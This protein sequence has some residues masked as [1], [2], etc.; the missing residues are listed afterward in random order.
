MEFLESTLVDERDE[1]D[2]NNVQ[3]RVIGHVAD[4]PERTRRVLTNTEGAKIEAE[5]ISKDGDS[6]TCL[7]RGRRYTIKL[8]SLS[9]ADREFI[10]GW[11]P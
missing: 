5:L 8:E 11:E 6:V 1:L 3:L 9:E 7:V 2:R 4:L 10:R